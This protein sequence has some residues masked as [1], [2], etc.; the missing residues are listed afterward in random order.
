MSD[1]ID[2]V[3]F[4]PVLQQNL[5]C[6]KCFCQEIGLPSNFGDVFFEAGSIASEFFGVNFSIVL[7][8]GCFDFFSESLAFVGKFNLEIDTT[9]TVVAY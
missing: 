3:A 2:L 4:D 5:V 8:S 9:K 6:V 7:S 1:Q